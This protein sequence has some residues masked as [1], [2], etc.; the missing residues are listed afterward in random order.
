MMLSNPRR[1]HHAFVLFFFVLAAMLLAPLPTLSRVAIASKQ[2]TPFF[3]QV[4]R[5]RDGVIDAAEAAQWPVVAQAMARADRNG[6]GRID[7][8]EYGKAF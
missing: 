6:D 5:N 1:D 2:Q 7:K 4:D 3:E 8:V